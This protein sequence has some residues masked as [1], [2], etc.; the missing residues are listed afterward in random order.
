VLAELAAAA[1]SK[2]QPI[3]C[4]AFH[5]DYWDQ[6]GWKDP[7]SSAAYSRRQSAY[8]HVA[9]S[10]LIY[11]P[12]MIVNGTDEFVGSDRPRAAHAID[13]ALGRT[14]SARVVLHV[15]AGDAG[16]GGAPGTSTATIAY[17]VNGAPSDSVLQIAAVERGLVSSVSRGENSGR[18]LRHENVVRAFL[19]VPL[20]EGTNGTLVLT[21][22]PGIVAG[23]MS[24]IGYVQNPG[25]MA[26]LG[27]TAVAYQ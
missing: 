15:N 14:A 10:S 24:V 1:R 12:Q 23:N 8:A 19:T 13:A 17:S 26:I 11:T 22:P 2:G 25:T 7:F 6:L 16:S 5:V 3:Y 4:L 20:A 18:V 27:A 21:M 9:G